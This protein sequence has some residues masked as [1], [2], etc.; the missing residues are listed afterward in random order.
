MPW[1]TKYV[2][3][4]VKSVN[5]IFQDRK[6][7]SKRSSQQRKPSSTP[8]TASSLLLAATRRSRK[9]RPR[10]SLEVTCCTGRSIVGNASLHMDAEAS[11]ASATRL[12]EEA[13][14][15]VD[16]FTEDDFRNPPTVAYRKAREGSLYSLLLVDLKG[17]NSLHARSHRLAWVQHNIPGAAFARGDISA[18]TVC[19][20]YRAPCCRRGTMHVL[21]LV[22]E[23]RQ[24]CPLRE[25]S[26][27]FAEDCLRLSTWLSR[28][29]SAARRMVVCE[30]FRAHVQRSSAD[31]TD[32]DACSSSSV[33]LEMPTV[34]FH[35]L[36]SPKRPKSATTAFVFSEQNG[37]LPVSATSLAE[38]KLARP[39]DVSP[40]AS[41][42]ECP[43]RIK[44]F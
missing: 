18:G 12:A 4:L 22:F 43:K 35:K 28:F 9:Q 44:V 16:N 21:V 34:S 8:S 33:E 41:P 15:G 37:W 24:S 7:S 30:E 27:V 26:P 31:S 39:L 38:R 10:S 17:H 14:A 19:T 11:A 23:Q 6:M 32:S 36:E 25:I 29:G 13:G 42:K 1:F 20:P 3:G 2:E 40:C 5:V